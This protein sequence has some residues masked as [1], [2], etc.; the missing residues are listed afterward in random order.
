MLS[1]PL[2]HQLRFIA[3]EEK[4]KQLD[5]VQNLVPSLSR[6]YTS[7]PQGSFLEMFNESYNRTC[8]FCVLQV[9]GPR[10]TEMLPTYYYNTS[11]DEADHNKEK[12]TKLQ[13]RTL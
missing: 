2:E 10:A 8:L 12:C 5:N 6:P 9:Q 13:D 1:G 7:R 11:L 4:V 3:D